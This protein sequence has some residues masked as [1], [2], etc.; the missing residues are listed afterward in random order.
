MDRIP[1]FD[2][3][4]LAKP[5]VTA[6]L[7]LARLDLDQDRRAQLGIEVR[8][9]P[10]TVRQ[11]LSHSAGLP[12][13]LPF[14]GEP[15]AGQLRRGFP[16]GSHPLLREAAAGTS[17]YSDLGYRL[18]AELLERETGRPFPELGAEA[19]GLLPA[20]WTQAPTGIPDG[21]DAEAWR[22][23]APGVP[24]PPRTPFL[25]HDANAR[26]GMRG[27]A[28]FGTTPEG[29]KGALERWI[30]S[31]LPA[32]MAVETARA[33]D[34]GRWGLGLQRSLGGPGRFGELL[35]RVPS[36]LGGIHLLVSTD[37]G[38]APAAPAQG[39]GEP[40]AWWMHFGYT[41]PALFVRPEDWTCLCLL[42]HR[43]GPGGRMLDYG[44]LQARRWALLT[45]FLE[46]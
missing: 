9:E 18:L 21:P 34:G 44:Q 3:A 41:G 12:P 33:E 35:A 38:L 40:T 25:P 16:A 4:S 31:G 30:A 43:R 11:L 42:V 26:A 2:L 22:L 46:G 37:E 19:S 39:P 13:W 23:A 10:L 36:P 28:G 27:H 24:L 5:L 15:L 8:S 20:P 6:P 17:T 7:A 1:F 45:G 32:R 14:T 29:M